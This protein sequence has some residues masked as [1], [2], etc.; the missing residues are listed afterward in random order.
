MHGQYQRFPMFSA[1][2]RQEWRRGTHECV[3]HVASEDK[4]A[5][6]LPY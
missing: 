2:R 1:G 4:A 3:R 6:G 5:I